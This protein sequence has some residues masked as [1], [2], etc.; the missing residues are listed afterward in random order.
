MIIKYLNI[1]AIIFFIYSFYN[2]GWIPIASLKRRI[3][4]GYWKRRDNPNYSKVYLYLILSGTWLYVSLFEYI[5]K[6]LMK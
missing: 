2:L 5:K 3:K 6:L 4:K 1:I